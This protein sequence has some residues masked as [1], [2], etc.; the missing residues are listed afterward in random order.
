MTYN[1]SVSQLGGFET[2]SYC[3][4]GRLYSGTK[5]C[6]GAI[7]S[8][9]AKMLTGFCSKCN[10]NKSKM[11]SDELIEAEGLRDFF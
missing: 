1:N 5:N 8:I 2:N 3:V 4:S 11:V 7:H 10:I 6:C 9:N